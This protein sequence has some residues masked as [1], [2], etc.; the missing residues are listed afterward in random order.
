MCLEFTL[1]RKA[2]EK[3]EPRF[4]IGIENLPPKFV[5]HA[6]DLFTQLAT[7]IGNYVTH[8]HDSKVITLPQCF[9]TFHVSQVF[10]RN[11]DAIQVNFKSNSD[12]MMLLQTTYTRQC[13]ASVNKKLTFVVSVGELHSVGQSII[14]NRAIHIDTFYQRDEA[15]VEFEPLQKLVTSVHK[16]LNDLQVMNEYI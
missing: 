14:G 15:P 2:D 5:T 16:F 3:R 12:P 8:L 1:T 4:D 11:R 7:E 13:G 9:G 10:V 6:H